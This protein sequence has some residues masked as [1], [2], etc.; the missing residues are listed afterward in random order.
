MPKTTHAMTKRR[1]FLL[2]ALV[3]AVT[4]VMTWLVV[5]LFEDR[6][7]DEK[8]EAA[9]A[10]VTAFA[11][12]V[13][14]QLQRSLSSTMALA[15]FVRQSEENVLDNFDT[16]A[17][18]MIETYG[19]IDNLQL[20]IDGVVSHIYPL[21]GNEA[22]IGHDLLNDPARRTEAMSAI[23]SRSLTLA[24]P[25]TLVQGGVA[26]IGRSPVFITDATGVDR[27]WGFTIA[28]IRVATL[29]DAISLQQIA[30]QG[31]EH[32]L[33][34][35]HPDTGNRHVFDRS[36][37][38]DFQN[39]A[40]F[41]VN[42]PNAEW[43]LAIV[44]SG[45]WRPP[46]MAVFQILVPSLIGVL[47]ATLFYSY[48]IRTTERSQATEALRESEGRF[49]DLHEAAPHAYFSVNMDGRIHLVNGRA[50]ELLGYARDSLI[51][52]SVLELYA[53]TATGKG[54]AEQLNE[55]LRG[56]QE[57]RDEELEMRRADGSSVWVSLTVRLIRDARGKSV[58]RRAMA[59]DITER[60]RAEAVLRLHNEILANMAEGVYLIRTSDGVIVYANSKFDEMFGYGPGEPIGKHV[61]V[62]NAR[63]EK[64]PEEVGREIVEALNE[65][66]TWDG[67]V[68]NIKKNGETFWCHASVSTFDHHE[69]GQVWVSAHT[70]IT[71][72]K[73]AE[74][75]LRE[76]YDELARIHRWTG[77]DGVRA[78]EGGEGVTGAMIRG[79]EFG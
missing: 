43:A 33:S 3:F 67:E 69:Y 47:S 46:W 34:R 40:A 57:I 49:R 23:E 60:R 37:E 71:E 56:G 21:A 25:F 53:D 6:L 74:A 54:K 18:D 19:G 5:I 32:E 52:R 27:F 20:A 17:A 73:R 77:M 59:V 8:R 24:G 48:Q 70:D 11:S 9:D 28:L 55:R 15:S 13:E 31:Y 63:G 41:S 14:Q 1:I 64:T 7:I 68:L 4:F 30:D 12:A 65:N 29:L 61:S 35:T 75:A 44:P 72:R 22:A 76:L 62:V 78:A 38:T 2:T 66:G 79:L 45:G 50:T 51:G 10:V 36:T 39:P 16:I 26:V 58:E 42:V